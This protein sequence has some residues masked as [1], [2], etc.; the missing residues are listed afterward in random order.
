MILG[1]G[2]LSFF[3]WVTFFWGF[4]YL[5]RCLYF[6]IYPTEILWTIRW[7]LDCLGTSSWLVSVRLCIIWFFVYR[8]LF[9]EFWNCSHTHTLSW[10]WCWPLKFKLIM[11]RRSPID[12]NIS[13]QTQVLRFSVSPNSMSSW[14]N[15]KFLSWI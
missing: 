9:G 11:E 13:N 3:Y 10:L 2:W 8:S 1:L 14:S 5:R 15:L 12:N 7:I 4:L 6:F